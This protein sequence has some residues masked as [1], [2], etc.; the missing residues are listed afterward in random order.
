MRMGAPAMYDDAPQAALP[1]GRTE[2]TPAGVRAVFPTRAALAA[3][4]DHTLLKP[5]ATEAEVLALGEEAANHGFACAMVNPGWLPMLAERLP[6]VRLGTVI[7]FPLG[8]SL[9]VAKQAE[10]KAGARAGA[11]DLDMVLPIGALRSG[12]YGQVEQEI[13][14]L[15][16]IAHGEGAVLKV[17]L[18]TCLLNDE[19][20]QTATELC[21]AA[22]ANFVKTSTGFSTGG[23]TAA[24]VALLRRT[25]GGRC[26]VKA[27]GGVRSLADAVRMVEAGADRLGASASVRIVEEYAALLSQ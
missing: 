3:M 4:L 20:K 25:V 2:L 26:G 11:L 24:D 21:A 7:D 5:E 8:A 16:E 1:D 14:S 10:A 23:A 17:I 13:R 9:P 19:Q 15:V 22:G 12:R 27:S 6:G 18:E